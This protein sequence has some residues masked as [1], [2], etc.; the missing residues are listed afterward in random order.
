MTGCS[1]TLASVGAAFQLRAANRSPAGV[2]SLTTAGFFA[3][4]A[5]GSAPRVLPVP[6]VDAA[7]TETS[8]CS[9][10]MK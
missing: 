7:T 1:V 6:E 9:D 8:T 2:R 3:A 4:D 5:A 10:G